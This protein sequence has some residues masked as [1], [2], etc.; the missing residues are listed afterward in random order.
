MGPFPVNPGWLEQLFG[1][2]SPGS[3][4]HLVPSVC[5]LRIASPHVPVWS[6]ISTAASLGLAHLDCRKGQSLLIT[7]RTRHRTRRLTPTSAVGD[8]QTRLS[9]AQIQSAENIM[10]QTAPGPMARVFLRE[11]EVLW[12][13]YFFFLSPTPFLHRKMD[14]TSLHHCILYQIPLPVPCF[15]AWLQRCQ[16]S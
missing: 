6:A 3:G 2:G 11:R 15:P 16:S 14:W 4:P 8:P 5:G 13:V 1:S 9:C 12:C 10:N 7:A